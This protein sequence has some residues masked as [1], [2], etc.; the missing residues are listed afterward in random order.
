MGAVLCLFGAGAA[1]AQSELPQPTGTP[2]SIDFGQDPILNLARRE[3]AN[4]LFRATVA[5][6]V[7]R[8]PATDESRA[9]IDE[10]GAGLEGAR[11]SRY[12]SVDIQVST[13]RVISREFSDDPNNIIER[14]RA[15]T[16]TDALMSV[17]Q[18]L[19]DFG[20]GSGR[21]RAA[22]ARLRA[23]GADLEATA[24]RVALSTIAGWY[25]VF[26]YRALTQLS[27]AYV[28]SLR[29]MREAVQMRIDEGVSAQGDLAQ[30]DLYI[31]RAETRLAQ[32]RRQLAN[33]EATF[34]AW[35]GMPVPEVLDRAP[36]PA[37]HIATRDDA[38]L[39]A[40]EVATVRSAEAS[41]EAARQEARSARAE[42]LPQ[43]TAGIEAGRYGV[44]ETDRDY[45]VRGRVGLR[46]RLFGGT[47][48]RAEEYS[49]RA[50][51]AS[52]R[53]DRIREE[54]ERDAMIALSDV[55][56]LEQQLRALES[57]YMSSRRSR[58]VIIERF[59]V[60]RGT[61][62]D[63]AIAEDAYFDSA[64]AYIQS[65][66]ELDAAR[67]VLLSRTGRLLDTLDIAPISLGRHE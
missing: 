15:P 65:L 63:V 42:R 16:R 22:G 35:T 37:L 30:A 17:Q 26:G 62:F 64:T 18:T 57:S 31:A 59:R 33:A 43:I 46:Y 19:L 12:P 27:E 50:R 53:A 34:A 6:A 39:A 20:A 3:A 61:L 13:Y 36:T 38:E 45:D 48:P 47:D 40:A 8:H 1:V 11:E 58:D 21:V 7:R 66:T 54:A 28:N 29:E 56:A 9:G 52:A 4:D 55:Q 24:D 60:A 2:L 51:S 5:A 25:D 32:F 67:Y 44:F 49:A 23:A 41:A 10:A 14:S